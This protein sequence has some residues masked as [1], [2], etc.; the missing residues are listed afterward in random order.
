MTLEEACEI[1]EVSPQA[2]VEEIKQNYR[3]LL[4]VWHP[5]RYV[6]NPRR[7]AKAS[8]KTKEITVAYQ[9]LI[10]HVSSINS[11]A[12]TNPPPAVENPPP[13]NTVDEAQ[14]FEVVL[15]ICQRNP[16]WFK[17]GFDLNWH[18]QH[19]SNI[20][21][22]HYW[23][24]ITHQAESYFRTFGG[25]DWDLWIHDFSHHI[26]SIETLGVCQISIPDA[27]H[28]SLWRRPFGGKTV[29]NDRKAYVMMLN[30]LF[31]HQ[32]ETV[33]DLHGNQLVRRNVSRKT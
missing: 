1:L 32:I 18:L 23:Q 19:R 14:F 4:H 7:Q 8:E 25:K 17:K 29:E 12:E 5:D 22:K 27:P 28:G 30:A 24:Q 9:I 15:K 11:R 26:K 2:S 13:S 16:H 33:T 3:D 31:D 10:S 6:D 20:L 21:E